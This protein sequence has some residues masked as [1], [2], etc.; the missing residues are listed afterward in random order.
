M[1][2]IHKDLEDKTKLTLQAVLFN[3]TAF[4]PHSARHFL[5]ISKIPRLKKVHTTE[6]YYRYRV[7]DPNEFDKSSFR[8]VAISPHIKYIMGKLNNEIQK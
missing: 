3:K 5:S 8:T 6:D 1:S 2:K 7:R 4:D